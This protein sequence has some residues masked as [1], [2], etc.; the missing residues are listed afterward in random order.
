LIH[1]NLLLEAAQPTAILFSRMQTAGVESAYPAG[2]LVWRGAQGLTGGKRVRGR[3][4]YR[5]RSGRRCAHDQLHHLCPPLP[6]GGLVESCREGRS[7]RAMSCFTKIKIAARGT[8]I[9]VAEMSIESATIFVHPRVTCR[10]PVGS[11]QPAL[12]SVS[13]VLCQLV[14][15]QFALRTFKRAQ[16][17]TNSAAL[18]TD[19]H[20]SS[21]ALGAARSLDHARGFRHVMH[22]SW[23]RRERNTLSHR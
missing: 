16:I 21:F 3:H 23:V 13:L 4:R 7:R 10:V 22:S 17:G 9:I 1:V 19:Q 18:D 11:S 20:H 6:K 5:S 15:G 12:F 8:T 14:V 2:A